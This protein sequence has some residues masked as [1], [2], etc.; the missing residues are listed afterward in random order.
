MQVINKFCGAMLISGT[1]LNLTR[2]LPI[3]VN[4]EIN[5]Q[6][7]PPVTVEQMTQTSL[8]PGWLLS[9]LMGFFFRALDNYW[10]HC[11][12]SQPGH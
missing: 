4:E 3:Y 1:L 8:L 12:V 10:P 7:I 5:L 11:D 9:H 2:M 6:N